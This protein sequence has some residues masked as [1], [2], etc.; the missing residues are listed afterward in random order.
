MVW[1]DTNGGEIASKLSTISAKGYI[2]SNFDKIEH[3]KKS[4]T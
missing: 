1:E 3:T 4:N 2:E